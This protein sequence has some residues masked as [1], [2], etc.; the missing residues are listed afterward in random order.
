MQNLQLCPPA[1]MPGT[2]PQTVSGGGSSNSSSSGGNVRHMFVPP[3]TPPSS[4]PGSPGSSMAAAAAHAAASQ[5]QHQNQQQ[6]PRRTTP[7]PPYQQQQLQQQQQHSQQ[8][9]HPLSSI[10]PNIINLHSGSTT[11]S[12]A[13]HLVSPGRTLTALGGQS[14]NSILANAPANG[15]ATN[16][17]TS[18][19]VQNSSN[20]R[21]GNSTSATTPAHL[22][23]LI[24]P[25]VRTVRYNR[26][27]NPELEKRRIHHCDYVGKCRLGKVSFHQ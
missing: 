20:S 21:G 23:N 18:N 11:S 10:C 7:P 22:A 9:G 1:A 15:S 13:G 8:Q 4:D 19:S 12:A 3:L 5:Q 16:H 6:L 25:T 14:S 2:Q 27:N 17:S 24:V 26:R